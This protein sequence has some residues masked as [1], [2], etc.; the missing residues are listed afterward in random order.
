MGAVPSPD[1]AGRD[2]CPSASHTQEGLRT[3]DSLPLPSIQGQVPGAF[4]FQL[5][6]VLL[7]IC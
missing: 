7:S 1:G 2:G 4:Y 3:F 5:P 6:I